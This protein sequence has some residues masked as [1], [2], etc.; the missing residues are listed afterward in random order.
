MRSGVGVPKVPTVALLHVEFEKSSKALAFQNDNYHATHHASPDSR[1]PVS[2]PPADP[3]P[4][5]DSTIVK[6]LAKSTLDLACQFSAAMH[7]TMPLVESLHNGQVQ[8]SAR[9]AQSVYL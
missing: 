4:T 1:V 3:N 8:D 7:C 2:S 6:P 9:D 5:T